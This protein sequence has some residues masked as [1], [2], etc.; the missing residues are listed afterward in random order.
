MIVLDT[1]VVSALMRPALHGVVV[2]WLNTKPADSIWI[3]S[4]GVLESR[5]GI[6]RLPEGR[7]KREMAAAFDTILKDIIVGRVL[8]FDTTAA[9]AAASIAA[10]RITAGL[11]IDTLDTQIAGIC[12]SRGATLATRNIKDFDGLDIPLINPWAD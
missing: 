8:A 4:I 5:S 12:V 7:R 1:N 2:L 9:E 6:L 10:R 3:T 11:N